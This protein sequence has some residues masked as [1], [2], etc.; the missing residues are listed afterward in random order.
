M[1]NPELLY[2]A[3]FGKNVEIC[4]EFSRFVANFS[5]KL[6]ISCI[7]II[8]AVRFFYDNENRL[9]EIRAEL[10]EPV[11]TRYRKKLKNIARH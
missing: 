1:R 5:L 6:L 10:F 8:F 9:V 2:R 7:S 11:D 4:L 3:L